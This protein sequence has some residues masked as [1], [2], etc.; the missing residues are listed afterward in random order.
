MVLVTKPARRQG[1][2]TRLLQRCLAE[3]EATRRGG[4]PR[5]DGARAAGLSAARLSRRLSAVALARRGGRSGTPS[6][7]RT[8]VRVRSA[9]A[10]GPAAHRRTR[11]RRI[12][13]CARAHPRAPAGAARRRW[14]TSPSAA[15]AR[16][17]AMRWA[18]TDIAPCMSGRSWPRRR[19]SGWRCSRR[20]MA[21]TDG[22][23]DP[24]RA[25]PAWRHHDSGS[26]DQGATAPRGFMR[27]LRGPCPAVEDARPHLRPCRARSW[28]E[29]EELRCAARTG[30]TF[31]PTCWPSC[32][33]AR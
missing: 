1:H 13:L 19:R 20:A 24:G 32:A 15:M 26:R 21:A 17:P 14:R 25:R 22:A 7:H 9:T 29:E 10:G 8:G 11:C 12:G 30:P 6:S 27:M 31:P 16:S 2:G 33:A 18:A 4:G 5:C 28:R 23:R 3:I